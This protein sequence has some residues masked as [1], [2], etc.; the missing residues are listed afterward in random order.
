MS[1]EYIAAIALMIVGIFK[2]FG[3]QVGSDSITGILTGGI[4]LFIAIR[5]VKKGDITLG[6][7]RK[8]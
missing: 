8:V 3:I 7:V 6:G 5:R 2:A 1:Q 4:A